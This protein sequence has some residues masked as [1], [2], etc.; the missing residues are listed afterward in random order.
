[1]LALLDAI[2]DL[3]F[4]IT[5]DGTY[6]DFA[7][8]AALLANPWERVV[9]GRMEDLLPPEVAGPLLATIRRALESRRLETVDYVLTT[10]AGDEREFEARVVPIDDHEVVT[11]VRDATELRQT[12]RELRDANERLVQAREAE[13]RRLERNLHD[14]AQQ[15]LIVALQALRVAMAR[16]PGGGG[17]E[18][19]L[20]ARAE[21]QLAWAI[22][23]IRELARGLHPTVLAEEGLAAALGQLV[24][25][26]DGIVPVEI[27]V[28]S[29]R[30]DP[31]LEACT[32]YLVAEALSNAAKYAGAT[33]L[34]VRVVG[35]VD[36]VSV[37]V[38]DDGCGG[39]RASAGGGLEGLAERVAALGGSL[40]IESPPG[41][42]TRLHAELPVPLHLS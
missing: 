41:G 13:R 35:A 21:E 42:G 25:R 14:G 12:E 7:G 6:V 26:L 2:P 30:L 10:M 3:M 20:L 1:M 22:G 27:D 17:P 34:Q 5:A 31:E 8:D 37:D 16:L 38:A 28:P 24:S 23:E 4:R 9:G 40:S 18:R 36:V 39:A 15:R 32:Y 29:A 33:S 19:D 11:I